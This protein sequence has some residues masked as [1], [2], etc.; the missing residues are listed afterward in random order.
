MSKFDNRFDVNSFLNKIAQ[1]ESSGGRDFNHRE[2]AS[3][4][5][6]GDRAIG[7]YGLMPNT[8]QEINRRETLMGKLDPEM[9]SAASLPHD[10]MKQYLEANPDVEQRFAQAYGQ[11]LREKFPGDE[12]KMAFG[13]TMGPNRP[14]P[15]NNQLDKSDYVNKFRRVNEMMKNRQVLENVQQEPL[16]PRMGDVKLQEKRPKVEEE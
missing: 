9:A 16:E 6:T 12:E 11:H 10:Q 14:E 13:W 2:I 3:G 5:H 1:I 7:R 4:M 15:S 8:I